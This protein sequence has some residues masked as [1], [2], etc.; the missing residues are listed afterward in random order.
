M[1]DMSIP[2]KAGV[3]KITNIVNKKVYIGSSKSIR[4]RLLDHICLLRKKRHHFGHLQRAY[5]LYGSDKFLFEVI[6][7]CSNYLEKEQEILDIY[8]LSEEK[9]ADIYNSHSKVGSERAGN[10]K[11]MTG[12]NHPMFGKTQTDEARKLMSDA[13][14]AAW[15]TDWYKKMQ[16]EIHLGSKGFNHSPETVEKCK[17]SFIIR[18]NLK[19]IEATNIVTKEKLYTMT[20]KDM[21]KLLGVSDT[22]IRR[23]LDTECFGANKTLINGVW[24]INYSSR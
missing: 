24:E 21:G 18:K 2:R 1:L 17:Q 3:Y 4:A 23:R 13:S 11:P 8:F 14:R 16:H 22:S 12:I 7:V 19:E 6:E 5:D 10:K 20:Y 9:R 15:N